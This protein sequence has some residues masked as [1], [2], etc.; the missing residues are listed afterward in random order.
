MLIH[1]PLRLISELLYVVSLKMLRK[2]LLQLIFSIT[3]ESSEYFHVFFLHSRLSRLCVSTGDIVSAGSCATWCGDG[4][5]VILLT[6]SSVEA[7]ACWRGVEFGKEEKWEFDGVGEIALVKM[8]S[9]WNRKMFLRQDA[10]WDNKIKR[11]QMIRRE[12]WT[13]SSLKE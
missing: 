6:F 2:I 9:G 12:L 11:K 8:C 5:R 13:R 4:L 10:N 7:N 3:Y 1:W